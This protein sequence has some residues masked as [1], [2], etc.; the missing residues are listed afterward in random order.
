MAFVIKRQHS[1]R[2]GNRSTHTGEKEYYKPFRAA[3]KITKQQ[4]H[5]KKTQIQKY[6]KIKWNTVFLYYSVLHCYFTS[7]T[8]CSLMS[9][10]S[11]LTSPH[12]SAGLYLSWRL[13]WLHCHNP[14]TLPPL[15][16]TQEIY[17]S[18]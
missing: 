4:T 17:A 14:V 2:S 11:I 8:L 1:K 6:G 3:H 9:P 7:F 13:A 5:H 12:R 18:G 15:C 10:H 16:H